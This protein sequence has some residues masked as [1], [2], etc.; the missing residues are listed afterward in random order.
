MITLTG[1]IYSTAGALAAEVPI[2][3]DYLSD[4]AVADGMGIYSPRRSTETDANGEFSLPNVPSGR[5][6]MTVGGKARYTVTVPDNDNS[7]DFVDLLTEDANV[8]RGLGG[9]TFDIVENLTALKA[10]PSTP[11]NKVRALKSGPHPFFYYLHGDDA[12]LA[13][14]VNI[15]RADDNGGNWHWLPLMGV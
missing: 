6:Q 5:Y 10:I 1:T 3:L 8:T 15:V 4:P 13:D 7:Y 2:D 14:G 9:P 11:V 12:S